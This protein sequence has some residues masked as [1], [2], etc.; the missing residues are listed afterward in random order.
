[1]AGK[2]GSTEFRIYKTCGQRIGG[3]F[4]SH[5][6][7]LSRSMSIIFTRCSSKCIKLTIME[8]SFIYLHVHSF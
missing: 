5:C 1:M 7:Y 8:T 2:W 4:A 3:C 6:P